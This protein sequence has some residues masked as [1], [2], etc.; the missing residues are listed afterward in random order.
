MGGIV[1][2]ETLLLLTNEQPIPPPS[3]SQF[4]QETLHRE[5]AKVGPETTLNSTSRH[6]PDDAFAHSFMFP[7]IQGVL[8][9]DT[10]FL[11]L[12]PGMIAHG[13]EGGHKVA[14]GA[15][16]TYT[17]VASIFGRGSKSEPQVSSRVPATKAIG[18][19]PAS[20]ADAA[21]APKWQSWGK[22]AMFAGAAGAVAAGGMAALYSQREKISAGWTWARSH[23]LFVGE[24]FRPEH[25]RRRVE[26]IET[27][28]RERGIGGANLYTNL[29]Q[30]AREGYGVTAS[31]VGSERTFCNLP[32]YVKEGRDRWG[33]D[34]KHRLKWIKAV[35]DK[36]KDETMAHTTMFY[37]RDNP[38]FYALGENAKDLITQ[39][40]DQGWYATSQDPSRPDQGPGPTS[41]EVG[42]G[43]EKPDYDTDDAP[44]NEE[45]RD[46]ARDWEGL[47]LERVKNDEDKG[48]RMRD[49]E[50]DGS[51][52]V[53]KTAAND[54]TPLGPSQ[55]HEM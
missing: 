42:D 25:L 7:H 20:T 22:Y 28:C 18:P 50:L 33:E 30:G 52:I 43:W 31:M 15:Y 53:D 27:V 14:S 32:M 21:A 44:Q 17:E 24:L 13:L 51:V 55:S 47:E 26:S 34:R 36:A 5:T 49:E 6:P 19:P 40:V 8:A 41:D 29:G 46:V 48:V 16:N 45:E 12:E 35:N 9:F 2:A 1:A 11:G 23:L 10:P 4:N 37:P 39:W 3:S 54:E 38:G